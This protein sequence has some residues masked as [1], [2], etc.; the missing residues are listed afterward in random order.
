MIVEEIGKHQPITF[1]V[2]VQPDGKVADVAVMVYRES[3]GGQVRY[4][5]FLAQFTGKT[6]RHPMLPWGMRLTGCERCGRQ[7]G[8]PAP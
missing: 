1:M 6:L 4:A 7:Q 5:R 2:G 3:Y 8:C